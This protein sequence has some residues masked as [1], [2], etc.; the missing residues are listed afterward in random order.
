MHLNKRTCNIL[1]LDDCGSDP[2]DEKV[3]YIH[4]GSCIVCSRNISTEYLC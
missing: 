2:L 3:R 4:G 1:R